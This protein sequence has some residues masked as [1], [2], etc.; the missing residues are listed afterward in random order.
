MW[1]VANVA[2]LPD[3]L[4]TSGYDATAHVVRQLRLGRVPELLGSEVNTSPLPVARGGP[5]WSGHVVG[6]PG[7]M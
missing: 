4:V 3:C 6:S 7:E 2:R 5:S 1:G